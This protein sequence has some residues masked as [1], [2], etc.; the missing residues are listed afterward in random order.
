M[1][2]TTRVGSTSDTVSHLSVGGIKPSGDTW[3][4]AP[5]FLQTSVHALFPFPDFT[6]YPF[7]VISHN[8]E[9]NKFWIL[10]ALLANLE[11]ESGLED[12]NSEVKTDR[13]GIC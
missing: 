12:P 4:L 9:C 5:G 3:K 2:Q 6:P 1:G 13:S 7:T 8:H 11:P 10:W